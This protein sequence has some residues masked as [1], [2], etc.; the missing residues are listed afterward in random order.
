M[1]IMS[2]LIIYRSMQTKNSV[3]ADNRGQYR[4][5]ALFLPYF[6]Y[7]MGF[8]LFAIFLSQIISLVSSGVDSISRYSFILFSLFTLVEIFIFPLLFTF[9]LK[10]TRSII[11][12]SEGIY[13]CNYI[14]K[15]NSYGKTLTLAPVSNKPSV[16]RDRP[17][18]LRTKGRYGILSTIQRLLSMIL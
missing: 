12:T 7:F 16:F 14:C 5:K 9:W 4:F 8:I 15:P 3:F 13:S 17:P 6:S 18:R 11:L 2:R 10:R 1:G